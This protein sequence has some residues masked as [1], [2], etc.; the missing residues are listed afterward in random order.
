MA[1]RRGM[2][3]RTGLRSRLLC[4]V[5]PN[6]VKRPGLPLPRP[7]QVH[8]QWSSTFTDMTYLTEQVLKFTSLTWRST[9]P[10]AE[11]VTIYYSEL[12]AKLLARLKHVPGWSPA[13]L[14]SRLRTSRW[15][16]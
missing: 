2:V 12:I 5:G 14:R 4:T 11:P 3:V 16:L 10:A 15:F 6:L 8:L 7:L 1:P 13:T 9:M